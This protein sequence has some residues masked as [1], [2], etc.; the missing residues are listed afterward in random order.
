MA[1]DEIK[2]VISE[3]AELGGDV[4]E[5]SG[6]E[7][8]AHSGLVEVIRYAKDFGFETRLYTA[9]FHSFEPLINQLL[10]SEIDKVIFNLQGADPKTHEF[11]TRTKGSFES[12]IRSIKMIA[13]DLR[14]GVHFVPMKPNFKELK[15]VIQLCSNLQVNEVGILRFMPQ[16]RGDV[17]RSLLEP[18]K[19]EFKEIAEEAIRQF[20]YSEDPI[21][22]IGNPFNFCSLID[23][24]IPIQPCHAGLTSCLIK[25]NG[26]VA[27]CPAFK[28]N[29]RYVAGNIRKDTL[30]D[31]WRF[32]PVWHQFRLFDQKKLNG[33]C[34]SCKHLSSC[35][36]RCHSQRILAFRDI[37]QGPD[38]HC[39]VYE[40][41][42]NALNA[43]T[44]DI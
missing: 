38:P 15:N 18:S 26:E 39:F 19:S 16:G 10:S 21:I 5:I 33:L 20:H 13:R 43:Y 35:R 3:V 1:L 29:P 6:G 22:R 17:N 8:T 42:V 36:G 24:S 27:P 34:K 44:L 23:S 32:S 25:P 12:V 2:R 28:Q 9:G 11:I 14:V 41:Q 40:P 37:Y 7:P 4:I 30:T 31:I